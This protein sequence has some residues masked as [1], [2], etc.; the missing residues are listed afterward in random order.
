MLITC[1]THADAHNDKAHPFRSL[2]GQGWREVEGAAGRFRNLI[3]EET[4]SIEIVVSSPKTRC[5][6]TAILFGKAIS[7]LVAASEIQL[8]TGL[9][10]GSI[11]G[12]ELMDLANNIQGQHMLVSAHA[13]LVRALPAQA[14]MRA[15]VVRNGWFT[16]RPVLVLVNY[17]V[18]E[19]WD[20]AQVLACEGL[21]GEEWWNLLL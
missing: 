11:G 17:D 5:V 12:R 13:D 21:F 15:E 19:S 16:T 8:D 6:E 18:G 20:S 9:K 2:T 10:A 7:D 1:I 14:T 3:D 4:P